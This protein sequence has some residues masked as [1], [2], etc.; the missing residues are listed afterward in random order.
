MC[1]ISEGKEVVCVLLVDIRHI[2]KEYK[3]RLKGPKEFLFVC[4]CEVR[5]VVGVY[6]YVSFV[7]CNIYWRNRLLSHSRVT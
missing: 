2:A 6:E 4:F 7:C 3:H 5:Q 1:I